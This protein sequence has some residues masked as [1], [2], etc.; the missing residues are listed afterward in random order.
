MAKKIYTHEELMDL[1]IK[2]MHKSKPDLRKKV[3]PKVGAVLVSPNSEI[4]DVAHRSELRKGDHAEYT[5]LE[6]KNHGK[7]LTNCILYTTLEPC[8]DRNE[9]KIGC[10]FRII[11]ARIS[12]VYIGHPDPDPTVAG[13]GEELLIDAGIEVKYFEGNYKDII[14][15]EN[16]EYFKEKEALAL[17]VK[18]KEINQVPRPLEQEVAN[19]N[20]SDFSEEAQQELINR[21][22]LKFKQGS[23]SY[24]SFLNHISFIKTGRKGTAA[25]PT[26]LGLL[27]LG[28]YPQLHFPQARIKF[29]I[30]RQGKEPVIKDFDG[31]LV[32]MPGKVEEYLN[33]VF[34]TEINREDFHRKEITD[35]LKKPLREIIINA[36]VHRDYLI[37]GARVMVDVYDDRIEI[38]SP[39]VPKFSL[40]EFRNYEVPSVSRNQMI[41][42]IFNKMHLVEERGLG[43][44]ELKL[45]KEAGNP[46]EFRMNGDFFVTTIFRRKPSLIIPKAAKGL[47]ELRDHKVLSTPRYMELTGLPERTARRHLNDLV[48]KGLAEPV[49]KGPSREYRLIEK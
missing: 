16:E 48:T 19:F 5:L 31:P 47:K 40:D 41:T 23:E 18:T 3:D 34:P 37:Q 35:S 22:E 13:R 44:K 10:T 42:F 38:S 6:R 28:K 49:G 30:H 15:A 43:M 25:R 1:S 26:G 8:V 21:M 29:T 46:S 7:D 20:I 27:M 24:N 17:K 2:E 33:N 12:K 9:P 14:A 39:G 4:L 32:L 36:I 11:N 45:L